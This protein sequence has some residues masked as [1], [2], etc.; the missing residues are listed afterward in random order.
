MLYEGSAALGQ[1]YI[2]TDAHTHPYEQGYLYFW[3]EVDKAVVGMGFP[4]M[5][6]AILPNPKP[7]P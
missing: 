2:I 6:S 7:R 3:E 4:S 5:C 1:F